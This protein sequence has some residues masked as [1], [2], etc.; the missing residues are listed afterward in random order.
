VHGQG[1]LIVGTKDY[2]LKIA[3]K[4]PDQDNFKWNMVVYSDI[5]WAGEKKIITVFQDM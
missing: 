3:P 1:D 5:N 2:G 4:K